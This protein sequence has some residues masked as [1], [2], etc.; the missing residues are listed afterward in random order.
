MKQLENTNAMNKV[1]VI[2]NKRFTFSGKL[3]RFIKFI[4]MPLILSDSYKKTVMLDKI[5]VNL[6]IGN[7]LKS[8]GTI[9][10]RIEHEKDKLEAKTKRTVLESMIVPSCKSIFKTRASA[11]PFLAILRQKTGK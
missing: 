11:D 10:N 6:L 4:V 2:L 1:I 8:L 9:M 5:R 7:K 3:Y